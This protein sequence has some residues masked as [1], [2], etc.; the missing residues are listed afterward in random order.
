MEHNII[1][2][3][4]LRKGTDM[5]KIYDKLCV[6]V[7]QIRKKTDLIPKTA[8][9]LGSGLGDFANKIKVDCIINYSEL[10]DFPVSTNAMHAGR[11]VLGYLCDI[12]VIIMDGRIHYYE[13]YPMEE[14]VMP[15]RLLSML[16]AKN[17]IL[18]NAAGGIH[19]DFNP[20]DFMIITDHIASFVP[21]PLIGNNIEQLGIRFPD[22]T[23]VYNKEF[24]KILKQC[25]S[26][27][28]IDIKEGV[29][30]QTTGPEYETPAEIK[31][32]RMLGADAV[33]MST[34]C[35]AIAAVHCGMNVCGISCIT[36]KA[37][38]MT[39][40]PLDDNEVGKT[41]SSVSKTFQLLLTD[42]TKSI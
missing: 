39:S 3:Y 33:G 21:S 36:N 38:G 27:L 16:G 13:G 2:R 8:I 12:P 19:Y 17:L 20:G 18:T 29:Y 15:I 22:M 40:A 35:E 5:N 11:F 37:A 1:I 14:V 9:V 24:I 25:A 26:N 7:E 6:N 32:Y 41:A 4:L 23:N 30:L 34:A 42:F 10:T 31:M 28:H